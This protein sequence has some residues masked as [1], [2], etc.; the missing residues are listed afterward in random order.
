V[1][2]HPNCNVF[3][4]RSASFNSYINIIQLLL[5]NGA[6]IQRAVETGETAI[7]AA[8]IADSQ[9]SLICLLERGANPNHKN[10]DG[11]SPLQ[12]A[13]SLGRLELITILLEHEADIDATDKLALTALHQAVERRIRICYLCFFK[14]VQ[15]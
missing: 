7:F 5:D 9:N 13:A 2:G 3:P 8:I 11:M 14:T 15:I 12:I 10:N 6:D 1:E 4:L